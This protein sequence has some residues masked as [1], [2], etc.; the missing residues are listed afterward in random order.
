VAPA[1]FEAVA[2]GLAPEPADR[3]VSMNALVEAL[4]IAA[5][6]RGRG[7]AGWVAVGAVAAVLVAVGAGG[8]A[9]RGTVVDPCAHPEQHLAGVW[10]DGVKQRVRAALVQSGRPY[11]PDTADRVAALLDRQAGSWTSMRGEVCTAART[12]EQTPAIVALREACLERRR[13]QM[14]ALTEL[15]AEKSDPD[16]L[17]KG[18]EAA[19]NLAP[20]SGCADIEALTSRVR[21]PEDPAL[22]ARVDALQPRIDR[23]EAL[24]TTGQYEAGIAEG[25]GLLPQ[26]R[27]VPYPLLTAQAARWLGLMQDGEG[28]YEPAKQLLREAASLAAEGGDDI[29]VAEAWARV[30]FITGDKQEHFDEAGVIRTLG[31]TL[32]ARAHDD[33]ARAEWLSAEGAILGDMGKLDEAK[34]A[35]EQAV[36]LAEKAVGPEHTLLA[37]ALV[38]LSDAYYRSNDYAAQRRVMER[39]LEIRTRLLGPDHPF[40]GLA[41]YNLGV[42]LHMQG[43]IRAA[44]D[45]YDR[46]LPVLR[47][48][49]GPQHR[50]VGLVLSGLGAAH[51]DLGEWPDAVALEERALAVTEAALGPDH[52]L[53]AL[54]EANLGSVLLHSGDVPKAEPIY[55]RALATWEKAVGPTHP[56]LAYALAGLGRVRTWQHR[57]DEARAYLERG[58]AVR[59]KAAFPEDS[60]LADVLQALGELEL[61]RG[62]PA[63]AV[64]PLERGLAVHGAQAR[65]DETADMKLLLADALWRSGWDHARARA[66]AEEAHAGYESVGHRPGQAKATQ[67]LVAHPG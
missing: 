55:L 42:A 38:N 59:E 49:L 43:E 63:A 35:G 40:V 67:W 52:T 13:S 39:A 4:T 34:A 10:D 32:L 58:R 21:P 31:P 18:V 37:D 7:R 62:K 60:T 33:R 51:D 30:L 19:Q 27:A 66:L 48:A 12:Q 25:E 29:L 22:R 23:L 45:L 65:A 57:F 46:A 41:T 26:L 24:Y 3:H 16:V 8:W 17:D 11:A 9:K 2:R 54:Y 1:V 28:K 20:V 6:P 47:S 15:L 36:A 64:G 50:Y 5:T 53:V 56:D 14:R 44:M 61:A